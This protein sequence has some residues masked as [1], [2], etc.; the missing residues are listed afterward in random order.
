[1]TRLA[2]TLPELDPYE[3]LEVARSAT[4]AEIRRS[5]KRL[6]L[7]AHPDKNPLRREW[8]ERRVR[9]LLQAFELI[10]DAEKRR[11]FD[12]A[13]RHATATLRARPRRKPTEK[14][15]FF[16]RR[17]DSEC[18][19]LRILYFLMHRRGQEALDLLTGLEERD[20]VDFLR[21]QLEPD[22]YLDCFFLLGEF[23]MERKRYADAL[24]RL[25]TLIRAQRSP[26]LR[27]PHYSLAVDL[28]KALYLRHLPRVLSRRELIEILAAPPE[29][30]PW[31]AKENVRRLFCL[32]R[33]SQ[34]VGDLEEARRFAEQAERFESRLTDA[35]RGSSG[36][37]SSAS[38]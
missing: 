32:A 2:G 28:L 1:M 33:A 27:R 21:E 37:S 26:R 36:V 9:V 16:F 35:S 24:P 15:L 34:D 5:Y 4:S 23:L 30:M 17:H 38:R 12:I 14:D 19:A 10:G 11:A 22:D 25:L 18:L 7:K 31:T 8:S 29:G 20:G 13:S 3:V 6:V